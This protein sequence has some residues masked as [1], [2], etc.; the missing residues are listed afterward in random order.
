MMLE[1][2]FI[3]INYVALIDKSGKSNFGIMFPDFPGCGF[4]GKNLDEAL[5]NARSGL[6][7]HLEGM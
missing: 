3:Y 7:F 5:E 4:A 6:I 1:D 2:A